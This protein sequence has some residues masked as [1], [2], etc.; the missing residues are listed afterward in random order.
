MRYEIPLFSALRL[1]VRRFK[2]YIYEDLS[3]MNIKGNATDPLTKIPQRQF[4]SIASSSISL[5]KNPG[6]NA[7]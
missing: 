3:Y 7:E 5:A 2:L 6:D 4:A 1:A